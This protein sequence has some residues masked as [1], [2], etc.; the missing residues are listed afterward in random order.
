V[1]GRDSS[2]T[3]TA[4]QVKKATTFSRTG[5]SGRFG[6]GG[7]ARCGDRGLHLSISGWTCLSFR[8][9]QNP[10][11]TR[12]SWETRRTSRSDVDARLFILR[13]A[14]RRASFGQSR[15]PPSKILGRHSLHCRW[16]AWSYPACHLASFR[17]RPPPGRPAIS[18]LDHRTTA[19]ILRQSQLMINQLANKCCVTGLLI[20]KFNVKVRLSTAIEARG[21]FRLSFVSRIK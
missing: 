14:R 4:F 17:C 15:K 19:K 13:S 5:A 8:Y 11:A 16:V 7:T 20:L 3:K 12:G 21:I 10:A 9:R 6:S 2:P 18:R 1:A